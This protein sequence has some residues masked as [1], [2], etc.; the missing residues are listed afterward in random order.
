MTT[1]DWTGECRPPA[2]RAF[3]N[4]D[5]HVQDRIVGN[6]DIEHRSGAYKPGDDE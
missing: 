5:G 3:E 2:V 4:L 1:S 6:Y